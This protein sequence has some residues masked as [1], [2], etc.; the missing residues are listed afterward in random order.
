MRTRAGVRTGLAM[1]IAVL[2]GTGSMWG[3]PAAG[4]AAPS[5]ATLQ[6]LQAPAGAKPD[7]PSLKGKVVVLEFWAT[8]CSPCVASLPYF[9]RLVNSLDP[10]KFQFLSI[11]DE[12]RK[13]VERFLGTKKMSGW[14]GLDASGGVFREYG[15]E[16]RPTTVVVDGSGKIVAVTEIESLKA[17]D[18][19]AVAAGRHV[20][21]PPGLEI[22][23]A[24]APSGTKSE[25]LFSVSVSKAAPDA[26]MAIAKHPP[27]GTDYLGQDADSLLADVLN[28]FGSRRYVLKS[29]L[30]E[31]RYDLRVQ[32][33][34]VS[35][36]VAD[37]VAQ[38]AV[39]AA[40]HLQIQ[41][42]TVRRAAYVLRATEASKRLLSPSASGHGVKRGSWDGRFLLMNGTMDDLASILATGLETPV[43]NETGI[44]GRYD[45]R[46]QVAGGD[47]ESMNAVLRKALGLE[48]VPGTQEML[49]NVEEV[50]EEAEG[51]PGA[52]A[53]AATT[54]R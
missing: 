43:L 18:L 33:G 41:P 51:K 36:R 31:G 5:L 27:T 21:F 16:A 34:E 26:K 13:T 9:D 10:A 46:F 24:A 11:D 42:R 4:T 8:W 37:S 14:V 32:T 1:L 44:A 29:R 39:L 40:L 23:E 50:S 48:L 15:V 54:P 45:A 6:L 25:A 49:L 30:P 38:Q 7:W 35:Q 28:V 20:E 12:D 47:L 17:A 3:Y 19:R 52:S 2:L 53:K 22:T